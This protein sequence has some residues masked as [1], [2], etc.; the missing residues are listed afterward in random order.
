[1]RFQASCTLSQVPRRNGPPSP[2]ICGRASSRR[3][4]SM[5]SGLGAPLG[6]LC[7]ARALTTAEARQ[8]STLMMR[9]LVLQRQLASAGVENS[10]RLS[11]TRSRRFKADPIE[12]EELSWP[13]LRLPFPCSGPRGAYWCGSFRALGC[14]F[15]WLR[16][17]A[18]SNA[19]NIAREPP[20]IPGRGQQRPATC[21]VPDRPAVWHGCQSEA[22]WVGYPTA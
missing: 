6:G 2:R 11:L 9:Q 7:S 21:V 22:S 1:M 17:R 20:C 8:R 14:P 19:P 18:G 10:L 13:D 4:L 16:G 12:E 15:A 3:F 5:L